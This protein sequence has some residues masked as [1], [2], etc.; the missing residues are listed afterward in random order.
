MSEPSLDTWCDSFVKEQV[1]PQAIQDQNV[2]GL[3]IDWSK[4]LEVVKAALPIILKIIFLLGGLASNRTPTEIQAAFNRFK[5][6][7]GP[8]KGKFRDRFVQRVANQLIEQDNTLS[9]EKAKY[10]AQKML[11]KLESSSPEQINQLVENA[12]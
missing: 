9:S 8:N 4:V 12:S 6:P 1:L 7:F 2:V 3:D 11:E 5:V 10:I